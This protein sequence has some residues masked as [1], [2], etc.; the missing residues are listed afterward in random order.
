MLWLISVQAL[1][2]LEL[3]VVIGPKSRGAG[4]SRIPEDTGLGRL[5]L[6]PRRLP[7]AEVHV[8][9]AVTTPQPPAAFK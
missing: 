4:L 5:S 6:R 1:P 3:N 7:A 2:A 8:S 9:V